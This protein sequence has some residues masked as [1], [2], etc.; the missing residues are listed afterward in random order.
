MTRITRRIVHCKA[1]QLARDYRIACLKKGIRCDCPRINSHWVTDWAEDKKVS[2]HD[3]YYTFMRELR[4]KSEE[5]ERAG[6][7]HRCAHVV[8]NIN[9]TGGVL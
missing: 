4:R 8:T 9:T 2:F 7:R 1:Q 6:L 5:F 3:T